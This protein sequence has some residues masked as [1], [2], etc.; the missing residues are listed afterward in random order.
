MIKV[1]VF[2]W[3]WQTLWNTRHNSYKVLSCHCKNADIWGNGKFPEC[4]FV[5]RLIPEVFLYKKKFKWSFIDSYFC[6]VT[7]RTI[8]ICQMRGQF[9]PLP[10]LND[11]HILPQALA[12]LVC[13][14]NWWTS[15]PRQPCHSI[16]VNQAPFFILFSGHICFI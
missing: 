14:S 13:L 9:M 10:S 15:E 12:C 3:Y 11:I 4:F 7:M 6:T 8:A 16:L 5:Y 1:N 2:R